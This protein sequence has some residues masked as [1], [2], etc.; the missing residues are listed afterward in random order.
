MKHHLLPLLT[1]A[2]RG[3]YHRLLPL[4]SPALASALL[5]GLLACAKKPQ[6]SVAATLPAA[7]SPAAVEAGPATGLIGFAAENGGTTGGAGGRTVTASTLAELLEFAKSS[8]PLVITIDRP[9]SAGTQ[10]ASVNVNS[11]KTLLGVGKNGFLEGVGLNISSKRNII[12]QNLKFTMSTVTNTK[13]NDE[14]RPQ[15]AVNDGD[16]I[17]IQGSSQ[18]IWVDHCEFFNQDPAT[19]P[20]QDL[21]DGLI[22][23]KGASAYITISWSYFHDHHKAHLIGNSDK[24]TGDRKVTFHHN[25]YNNIHERVPVYRFGTGHVFNNYYKHVYGTGINS[26]MDAC[27]RVEKN[28]FEDTKDPVTTKNSSVPGKWDAADNLYVG[29]SGSQP[30]TSSCSFT[31]PYAYASALHEA[32]QVREIV[33]KGAGVGRL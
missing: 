28:Y 25:Y 14:K 29:C 19:Q 13:I 5:L 12:V 7:T 9:I 24:D 3:G 32:A 22:D 21:Y 30:T 20:N 23:A 26:R 1:A 31:P 4:T 17:T 15:V 27:V 11:N 18:N 16:C 6:E 10:G 2:R 33:V 8:E